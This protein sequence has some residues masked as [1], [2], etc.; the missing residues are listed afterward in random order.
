[1]NFAKKIFFNINVILNIFTHHCFFVSLQLETDI[2]I[3]IPKQ[4]KWD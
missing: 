4:K 2:I 1:M 3:V